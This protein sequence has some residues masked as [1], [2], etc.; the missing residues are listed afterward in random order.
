LSAFDTILDAAGQTDMHSSDQSDDEA[1]VYTWL[2]TKDGK[3]TGIQS[4]AD[5]STTSKWDDIKWC[6]GFE[7]ELKTRIA[8][9]QD[10]FARWKDHFRKKPSDVE[11]WW[12]TR[13]LSGINATWADRG[14]VEEKITFVLKTQKDLLDD[15]ANKSKDGD[16]QVKFVTNAYNAHAK[17]HDEDGN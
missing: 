12:S 4:A 1:R 10:E 5:L 16:H 15:L 6:A 3:L 2:E 14:P 11:T 13:V 17:S 9:D 8:L 7:R